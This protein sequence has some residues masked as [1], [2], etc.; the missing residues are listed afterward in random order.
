MPPAPQPI[1]PGDLDA[2][3]SAVYIK[4]VCA[5]FVR[6]KLARP[7]VKDV[8]WHCWTIFL[9][10]NCGL[11]LSPFVEKVT[12]V[13]H[14]DFSSYVRSVYD[15]PYETTVI[16]QLGFEAFIH[17]TYRDS[18]LPSSIISISI[19]IDGD[20]YTRRIYPDMLV[21]V[22]PR[23]WFSRL[24]D[25]ERICTK[26]SSILHHLS[27]Q[28]FIRQENA[29][30]HI[31][32]VF[33][34]STK[35]TLND[36]VPLE[37]AIKQEGSPRNGTAF[38]KTDS[39]QAEYLYPPAG[40]SVGLYHCSSAATNIFKDTIDRSAEFIAKYVSDICARKTDQHQQ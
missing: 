38:Y 29:V 16:G 23:F 3:V 37:E 40:E 22:N 31:P 5:G 7:P 28:Q 4:G 1:T 33:D 21:F 10:S 34:S 15:P 2:P 32:H 6:F 17:I 30:G 39:L 13:I 14:K 26:Q 27:L 20:D 18:K 35:V 12:F 25:I 36:G 19:V 11:D 9:A 8:A 24:L